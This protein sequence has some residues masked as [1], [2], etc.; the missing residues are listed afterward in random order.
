MGDR[1]SP[2]R[3]IAPSY[4]PPSIDGQQGH[5]NFNVLAVRISGRG[6]GVRVNPNIVRIVMHIEIYG[7]SLTLH[8][9]NEIKQYEAVSSDTTQAIRS[10]QKAGDGPEEKQ[11]IYA[12]L[13]FPVIGEN[14][15]G[16]HGIDGR[17][18]TQYCIRS[19]S[20]PYA[21]TF[22]YVIRYPPC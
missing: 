9:F 11:P 18:H 22:H 14:S 1:S 3:T 6:E 5:L 15:D 17:P 8:S 4:I 16:V 10:Q 20:R 21:I 19:H 7:R 13:V 2:A 12:D